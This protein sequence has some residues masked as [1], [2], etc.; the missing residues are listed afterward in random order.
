MLCAL[1]SSDPQCQPDD[2]EDALSDK[3]EVL[4]VECLICQ[5]QKRASCTLNSLLLRTRTT[6]TGGPMSSRKINPVANRS[7]SSRTTPKKDSNALLRYHCTKYL[8]E[9]LHMMSSARSLNISKPIPIIILSTT[10]S[11][12]HMNV[13]RHLLVYSSFSCPTLMRAIAA[14]GAS[15]SRQQGQDDPT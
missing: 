12:T 2:G 7:T 11:K 5:R 9:D 6:W 1:S 15:P 13:S 3:S 4:E 8:R 14:L 10:D